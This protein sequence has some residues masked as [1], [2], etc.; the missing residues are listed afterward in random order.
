MLL[1]KLV[2]KLFKILND[3]QSLEIQFFW[4]KFKFG[5]KLLTIFLNI[6]LYFYI[7]KVN[8]KAMRH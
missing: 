5:I 7:M 8:V 2:F 3:G 6:I 1:P 4:V